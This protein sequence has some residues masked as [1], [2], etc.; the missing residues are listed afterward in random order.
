MTDLNDLIRRKIEV[1]AQLDAIEAQI[2]SALNEGLIEIAELLH[3]IKCNYN[4]TDGCGWLY[5]QDYNKNNLAV[6]WAKNAH[7][8]YLRM[9]KKFVS[10][11]E[12]EGIDHKTI[13]KVLKASLKP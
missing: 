2:D 8:S 6:L 4:H 1:E 13:A 11:P 7:L 3:G 5:E 12:L 10:K 9:A